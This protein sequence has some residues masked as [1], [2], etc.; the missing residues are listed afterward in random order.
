VE[1]G[2]KMSKLRVMAFSRRILRGPGKLLPT[3]G[4]RFKFQSNLHRRKGELEGSDQ[5]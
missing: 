2:E 4:L 3:E 5:V 1:F